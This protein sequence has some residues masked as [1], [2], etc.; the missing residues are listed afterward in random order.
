MRARKFWGTLYFF[1]TRVET[2]YKALPVPLLWLIRSVCTWSVAMS[3]K[4]SLASW[5]R[6]FS[7]HWRS[8]RLG[9]RRHLSRPSFLMSRRARSPTSPEYILALKLGDHLIS[10]LVSPPWVVIPRKLGLTRF[11][12]S[13]IESCCLC[14]PFIVADN[15]LHI[16]FYPFIVLLLRSFKVQIVVLKLLRILTHIIHTEWSALFQGLVEWNF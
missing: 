15:H 2:W 9:I 14:V 8:P 10:A 6:M 11:F 3:R 13:T 7:N 12:G 1:D 16:S 5:N 4:C